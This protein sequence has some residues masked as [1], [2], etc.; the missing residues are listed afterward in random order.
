MICEKCNKRMATVHLTKIVNNKKSE[1]HLCQE[2]AKESG[3]LGFT[4]QPTFGF[5]NL[6]SGLFET[7]QHNLAVA[8]TNRCPLCGM[9][10]TDFRNAGRLGCS[11]C[12]RTFD[13]QLLPILH[14][15]QKSTEHTGK[16]PNRAGEAI[17]EKRRIEQLRAQLQEAIAREEYEKAAVIRDQLRAL[18]D[19]TGLGG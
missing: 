11:Q 1:M 15:V 16:V 6:I 12:Y 13:N 7:S 5:Q 18:E 8:E 17:K 3:E 4:I 9:S 2:C 19:H 14:R 10:I